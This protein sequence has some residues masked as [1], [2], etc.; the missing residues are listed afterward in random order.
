MHLS[1]MSPSIAGAQ[2]QHNRGERGSFA[3]S[4]DAD[5]PINSSIRGQFKKNP[6]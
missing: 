1:A 2:R 4:I 6:M 3:G 5:V